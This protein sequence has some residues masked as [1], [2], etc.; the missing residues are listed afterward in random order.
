LSKAKALKIVF[1]QMRSFVQ[2]QSNIHVA[3]GVHELLQLIRGEPD[4][5]MQHL[6]MC[7]SCC[8]LTGNRHIASARFKQKKK[9]VCMFLFHM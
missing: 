2:V 5:I 3:E 4:L 8:P 6:V 9:R 1:W 7:W